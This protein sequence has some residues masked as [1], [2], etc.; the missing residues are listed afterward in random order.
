MDTLHADLAFDAR[1]A[2]GEGALWHP[3]DRLLY[4]VDIYPGNLH[5]FN[6]ATGR[7]HVVAV[8]QML[9][10]VAIRAR[11]G[12][13]AGL[14]RGLAFLDPITGGVTPIADPEHARTG[15]RFNDG[16]CDPA[17]RFWAGTIGK[18]GSASL[19]RLDADLAL[20]V[21]V[22]G[23]TCSNGLAWSA[24]RRTLYYIDTPT[25]QISA[26]DYD[27][28]SGAICNRRVAIEIPRGEGHPDGMTIDAE[29]MLWVAYWCGSQVVRWDP[30]TGR[31]LLRV[32][33]PATRTT[34]CAFGGEKLDRLFITSSRADLDEAT[35]QAQPHSGGL[36]T[37]DP[38][39]VGVPPDTFAG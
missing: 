17:G 22:S 34:T 36:F 24:D 38:G 1:A 21:A 18:T 31:A 15:N 5:A 19:Y 2:L 9:G 33:V 4:W 8:G 14:E 20:H 32:A 25:G 3:Q 27:P 39:T 28:D 26:F 30:R 35:L 16:K 23:I 10:C 29:G 12:F 6:P 7:D 13:I 11:G 37:V